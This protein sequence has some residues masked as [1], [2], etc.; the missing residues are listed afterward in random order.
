EAAFP[1]V[2]LEATG[3]ARRFTIRMNHGPIPWWTLIPSRRVP[4]TGPL[5][6]A[7]GWRLAM[8]GPGV[9]VAEAVRDRGPVWRA[10]WEPLCVGVL[11]A[12]PDKAEARLLWR[13]IRETFLKGAGPSRPMFAPRGLGPALVDP[14]VARL[15]AVGAR[16]HLGRPVRAI[17]RAGGRV[18]ALA[19]AD[20]P[21]AIGPADAVILALPPS[22]LRP[23][24]PELD[25]PADEGA[26]LNAH[27]RIDRPGAL[28]AAPPLTGV[29]GGLAQWI[30]TRDDIVS[31]TVS[32]A[33]DL[34]IK[35]TPRPELAA[36]LWREVAEA[37]SLGVEDDVVP[38]S[39]L[40]VE[41]RATFDQSPA[42]V[43]RRLP[44]H[45]A[46]DN[47]L[48]A[49]DATDTGLPATIEGAVRSGET[50]AAAVAGL[51]VQARP[52]GRTGVA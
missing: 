39:R 28:D 50:A 31:V 26:I 47:L 43:A 1:M 15:E 44:A 19:F 51:T 10:F 29:L 46:L 48:L 17:E 41:K 8:A 40:I 45:T 27:F 4:G 21:V 3:A 11:N 33:H 13:V 25:P 42:G 32:A 24:M 35:A 9:T 30:F 36:R 7:G 5:A 37:L 38:P 12:F 16:L 14:A 18:T 20:G 52:P 6:L 2:D 49:G 23:L 22:R 34:G